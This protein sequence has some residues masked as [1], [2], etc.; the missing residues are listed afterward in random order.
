MEY[1]Y[2]LDRWKNRQIGFDQPSPNQ[3][4]LSHFNKLKL[5]RDDT[6]FVPLTG[7]SVDVAWLLGQGLN[8]IGNELSESATIEL[9]AM[10]EITPTISEWDS[11]K[12]YSSDSLSVFVGDFFELATDEIG[13]INAVYDRA[14]LVALPEEMRFRYTHHLIEITKAAPQLLIV[15]D[16]DQELVPGPPFSISGKEIL[17]QYSAEYS[18][19]RVAQK[20]VPGGIKGMAPAQECAWLLENK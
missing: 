17:E 11:G 9:F 19:S 5:E 14:A 3:L 7:K 4:L 13:S 10:L 2:W 6:V 8:V 16:Y 1:S 15:F 12:V 20:E 18:I